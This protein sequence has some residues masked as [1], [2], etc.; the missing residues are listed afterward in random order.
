MKK[1]NRKFTLISSTAIGLSAAGIL[2]FRSTTKQCNKEFKLTTKDLEDIDNFTKKDLENLKN[3]TIFDFRKEQLTSEM[4]D[5]FLKAMPNVTRL[6]FK[7]QLSDLGTNIPKSLFELHHKGCEIETS[8][9]DKLLLKF[10]NP[11]SEQE[12]EILTFA[13]KICTNL[14]PTEDDQWTSELLVQAIPHLSSLSRVCIWKEA[15]DMFGE[16]TCRALS[17]KNL[18]YIICENPTE[19]LFKN[20]SIVP[21]K[22]VK[23]TF[24]TRIEEGDA[25]VS[26]LSTLN[27]DKIVLVQ[28][29]RDS[30][31][32]DSDEN[33]SDEDEESKILK[34]FYK[35]Y[36]WWLEN[37]ENPQQPTPSD[38][39]KLNNAICFYFD[40]NLTN[41]A[42]LDRLLGCLNKVKDL[43]FEGHFTTLLQDSFL[44][45]LCE[46]H[47][48]GCKI[49][50]SF[51][52]DLI[53]KFQAPKNKEEE[54]I[55]NF[56]RA[57][58]TDFEPTEDFPWTEELLQKELSNLPKLK[59]VSLNHSHRSLLKLFAHSSLCNIK[60]EDPT[61]EDLEILKEIEVDIELIFSKTQ[62]NETICE[63]LPIL[64]AD[65]IIIRQKG[66]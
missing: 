29:S 65:T 45:R 27:A 13:R 23:L 4:L 64:N 33:D 42:Q 58:C 2:S 56:A 49:E 18:K 11:E 55:L 46:L 63:N 51:A 41:S 54:K 26:S 52:V 38:L 39:E 10:Q 8:Y 17:N 57:I 47:R 34:I 48:R 5:R 59:N 32:D 19:Q 31:D 3:A 25:I 36:C 60:I 15:H 66:K 1:L 61:I 21:S 30:D 6:A 28:P 62:F 12:Q 43:R 44:K 37:L 22:K 14:E 40:E 50:A 7:D 53:A 20:I 24:S 16:E 35:E 9:A